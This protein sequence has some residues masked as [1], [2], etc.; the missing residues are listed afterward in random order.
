MKS[1]AGP[2]LQVLIVEDELP[3][4]QLL[5]T[6]LLAEG[7]E[8]HEAETAKEGETIARHRPIDF[9]LVDLGLPDDDGVALIQRLRTWTRRPIIVLSARSQEHDKVKAL[10]AGAD[11]FLSKPFGVAELHAR[12]RVARRNSTPFNLGGRTV[13]KLG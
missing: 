6:T 12:L 1:Y 2:P 9:F 8:V 11:D 5:R 7:Y 13:L 10:D 3:I 4:R